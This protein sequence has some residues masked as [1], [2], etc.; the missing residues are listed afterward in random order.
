MNSNNNRITRNLINF[1]RK[2]HLIYLISIL[3]NKSKKK[4]PNSKNMKKTIS[5]KSI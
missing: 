5:L 4:K 3:R 2:F 1:H